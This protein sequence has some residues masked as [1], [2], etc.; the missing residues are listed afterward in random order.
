M[1]VRDEKTAMLRQVHALRGYGERELAKIASL[2]DF[3]QI[4]A[5][6]TVMREGS[7]GREMLIVAEGVANV[8][9]RGRRVAKVGPGQFLGE[10]S[11]L[12]GS[13][14][15]ATVTAETPLRALVTDPR[16]FA[17]L[18]RCPGVAREMA[19]TLARRLRLAEGALGGRRLSVPPL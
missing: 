5:G 14:R 1:R 9:I 3:V 12:D 7:P 13:P 2:F 11:L 15:S 4:P 10:M 19:G 6:E 16:R 17:S 18:V 8:S